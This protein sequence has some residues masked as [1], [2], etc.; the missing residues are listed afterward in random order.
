MS[1]SSTT[2]FQQMDDREVFYKHHDS[3]FY[4][5]LSYVLGKALAMI[6]QQIV[7]TLLLGGR[8]YQ[9]KNNLFLGKFFEFEEFSIAPF[10]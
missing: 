7:D 5:A 8:L 4:S 9:S 3:N 6:P 1:T 10:F 2:V